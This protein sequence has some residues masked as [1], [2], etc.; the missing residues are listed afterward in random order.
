MKAAGDQQEKFVIGLT[1]GIACGKSVAAA[2]LAGLGWD[3]VSTDAIASR[4][5]KEE[6]E[7]KAAVRDKFGDAIILPTGT[8]DK[9]RLGRVVFSDPARLRW[10]EE[11]LHPLIRKE[12]LSTVSGSTSVRFV[13]EI[14]LLF[15]NALE[16]RFS[17]IVSVFAHQRT[18]ML[19]LL[20]RGLDEA[21]ANARVQAQLPVAEKAL[22]ADCVL[23]GEGEI[24]HLEMQVERLSDILI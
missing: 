23:L 14:P 16:S 10:L 15:E 9:V 20:E 8:I 24:G 13:V 22:R 6:T 5:L 3:V 12:W 17:T 2:C 18:Q 7:V 19:R 11:L 4:L 21:Q 1:G